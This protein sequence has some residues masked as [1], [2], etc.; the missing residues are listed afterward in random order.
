ML[1]ESQSYHEELIEPSVAGS[2][3]SSADGLATL[4]HFFA[5]LRRRWLTA[6]LVWAALVCLFVPGI[7][8]VKK[9]AYTATAHVQVLPVLPRVLY[10]DEDNQQ[11]PQFESYLR[12]QAELAVSYQVLRAALT[13][14]A[15]KDLPM[16]GTADPASALRGA[17]TAEPLRGTQIVQISVTQPVAGD[18]IKLTKAIV[19]AYLAWAEDEEKRSKDD[20][21]SYLETEQS[22][23]RTLI[24]SKQQERNELAGEY[25]TTNLRTYD[26]LRESI[27]KSGMQTKDILESAELEILQLKD[28]IGQ[29]EEGVYVGL[30]DNSPMKQQQAVEDHPLVR[31]LRER[32]VVEST[33]LAQ[34]RS[35]MTDEAKEVIEARE[36]VE[37][38]QADLEKQRMRATEDLAKA[39]LA[40][41]K[42]MKEGLLAEKKAR[43]LA[44]ERHRDALLQRVTKQDAE[45]KRIGKAS[46]DIQTVQEEI[47]RY[48]KDLAVVEERIKLLTTESRRQ[49]RVSRASDPE[50]RPGS[51][52]DRRRRLSLAAVLGSFVIALVAAFLRDRVEARVFTPPE[53]E[54]DMGLTLLG[55]V[56][57]LSDLRLGRVT[58]QDFREC[59]RLIRVSLLSAASSGGPLKSIL[60]T[61]AQSGEGKT[62]TAVNLAASF[63]ERGNRVLLIDGDVQAPQIEEVLEI[64]APCGLEQVLLGESTLSDCVVHS[65]KGG[66][67]VLLAGAD[68]EKARHLLEDASASHLIAEAARE[69]DYVV[70]DSPPALGAADALVWAQAVDGV[71]ICTLAGQS[72]VK[73]TQMACHRLKMVRARLVGAVICNLASRVYY[74]SI[75]SRGAR[76]G[77]AGG[78]ARL[79]AARALPFVHLPVSDHEKPGAVAGA[80]GG[81]ERIDNVSVPREDSTG[82]A[83]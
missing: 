17:V 82:R 60:V 9:P 8:L 19:D 38:L 70:V 25:A 36:Q 31:S 75:S 68:S 13:D 1:H 52:N 11:M 16:L 29:I 44:A 23:L 53:V 28:Q 51:V 35:G 66:M 74:S 22:R 15:V 33:R 3:P 39:G 49:A 69:Y 58:P 62:S 48:T 26:S 12:T 57:P 32:L 78:G 73:I 79:T 65:D 41:Q 34:L 18:A 59:Y 20:N 46:L 30:L 37:Q 40:T 2:S 80:P 27:A 81:Q 6:L 43:L 45:A 24:L 14:P 47:D 63:A 83:G 56:P 21:R 42:R 64:G 71:V 5:V 77:S 4:A 61:S 50:L 54:G 72:S 10:K 55:V 67:D 7:Y 76:D